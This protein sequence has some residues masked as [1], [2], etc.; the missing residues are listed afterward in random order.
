[1]N[2]LFF[3]V[4]ILACSLFSQSNS[5]IYLHPN[6]PRYKKVEMGIKSELSNSVKIVSIISKNEVEIKS[7][8]DNN[9]P[10]IVIVSS[11]DLIKVWKKLQ[12]KYPELNQ[13]SSILLESE[14]TEN[15]LGG[16]SNSCVINSDT[17]LGQYIECAN[18]LTGKKPLN[19]GI[20]YSSKS[21]K[22]AQAYQKEG[23]KLN[24]TVYDKQVIASDPEGSIKS[25]VKNLTEIFNVDCIIILD[26]PVTINNQNVNTTWVSL[27]TGL[28]IPVAVP[29]EY[30]NEIEPKIGSL[31]IQ[32][33]Y[34][35]IGGVIASVINS[36]E[37]NNWY[38]NQKYIYTDKSI[39]YFRNKDGSIS[40]QN[41]VQND[42]VALYHPKNEAIPVLPQKV[43]V[44]IQPESSAEKQPV[45]LPNNIAIA[46]EERSSYNNTNLSFEPEIP[47]QKTV[48]V[49]PTVNS[50]KQDQNKGKKEK[51]PVV[52]EI[53]KTAP[54]EV[55][56]TNV[57]EINDDV[58]SPANSDPDQNPA[59]DQDIETAR[60]FQTDSDS[61]QLPPQEY[62]SN[63]FQNVLISII[64]ILIALIIVVIVAYILLNRRNDKNK[65]KCL[66][67]TDSKK[68]IKYS[69][70]MNKSI[71][72]SKYLKNC[73]FNTIVT[74]YL[75]QINDLLLFKM[76]EVICVDW[77][78]DSDIQVKFY[79][80]LKERMFSGEF[81]LIFYNV[82]DSAKTIIGYYEDRTFYLGTDFTIPD[83][84]KIL[85]IVKK[86]AHA[87]KQAD[88]KV[89]PQLEGKIGGDS[90]SEIFQMMDINKK[91]G[92]LI[93]ETD[94][95][96]GTIFFEDG[97]ITYAISNTQIAEQ[98]VFEILALR[99]GR[100]HFIPDKKPLSRNMQGSV[101]A[102][103]MEQA[104]STDESSEFDLIK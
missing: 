67:I 22:V 3:F 77:Q 83:L 12:L 84:N 97:L 85:S 98:A 87:K 53:K 80:I 58:F 86:R 48:Q 102:L 19:I 14:F 79:K 89:N 7:V 6:G 81:I 99:S 93:V 9:S 42:I 30:F 74:K 1:M 59:P 28:S 36:A 70:L 100:F 40:K 34:S 20:V 56:H 10:K 68:H 17:K 15:D 61:I 16:F 44:P 55:A 13:I 95:P 91:T 27:L 25:S 88:D 64:L 11:V 46:S 65:N 35:A 54:V 57:N 62:Q 39:F 45:A 5:V 23:A 103:L 52:K 104:Q 72:L 26:D 33:H 41:Y 31:A 94:H 90:L 71:A 96:L 47:A 32:Q 24:V 51:P 69:E 2:K 92:C 82:P 63:Q 60:T 37:T 73:G 66:L 18:Q 8:I 21:V 75:D 50:E 43:A 76:P 38:V 101:V 49:K 78:L 4:L 29:A